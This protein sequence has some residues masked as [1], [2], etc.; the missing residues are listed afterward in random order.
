MEARLYQIIG[1]Q[2][3]QQQRLVA[4]PKT[5]QEALTHYRASQRLFTTV[6][7]HA[8]DGEAIDGFELNRRAEAERDASKA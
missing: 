1:V 7:V 3:N 2:R 5:A 6:I 8:P 4:T